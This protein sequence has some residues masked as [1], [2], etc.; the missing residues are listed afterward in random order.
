MFQRRFVAMAIA[1]AVLAL[2]SAALATLEK[3]NNE[4]S[5]DRD[6]HSRHEGK[7]LTYVPL[8]KGGGGGRITRMV[9]I[10]TRF[11]HVAETSFG[12]D[13]ESLDRIDVREVP[14]F[15]SI[16]DKGLSA[17][18]F[19]PE[20]RVGSVYLAGDNSL[21]A[22]IDD[23]IDVA[24]QR[25]DVVTGPGRYQIQMTPR[26]I[27]TAPTDLGKFGELPSVEGLLTGNADPGTVIVLRG[28]TKTEVPEEGN[29]V[30]LLGDIPLLQSLF[31]GTVHQGE[32]KKLLIF[33]RPS[34]V[35]DD[36]DS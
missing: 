23:N 10:Q 6:G 12:V 28:L 36:P 26:L 25:L 13:F 4:Q 2:P 19:T 3:R 27:E 15:G 24:N 18:D 21:A 8:P 32:K 34:I 30:P 17:D 5:E 29:K 31:R 7:R 16:F 20:T 14:L 22:V 35:M 9:L 33:L 1:L 11:L